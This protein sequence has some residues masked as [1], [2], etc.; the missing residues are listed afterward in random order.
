M[1]RFDANLSQLY[2]EHPFLERFAAA[3]ADGFTGVEYRGPYHE[4]VGV[5]ADALRTHGLTQVLFNLPAGDWESGERGIGCLPGREAEFRDGLERA[6]E[7]AGALG[8]GQLNCLAGLMPDGIPYETLEEVLVSNLSY[9]AERLARAGIKLLIEVLN[10]RDLPRCMLASTDQFERIHARVGS[11]NLFLL[12]DFYHVQVM[13]GD[14]VRTFARLKDRIAHVQVADNPGRHE[15]GSGEIN[16]GFVFAE[17]ERFG[18]TGWIG[19]EYLPRGRTRAGLEWMRAV[20]P[21]CW[22]K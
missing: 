8:C 16:Y 14:I 1:V 5:I 10:R 20:T 12:Y 13:Q 18:Y 21:R 4:S 17:L 19:C 3:A 9:A 6:I 15:P 7:Y 2:T 11:G 22:H